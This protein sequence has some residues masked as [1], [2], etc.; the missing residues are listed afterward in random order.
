VYH[1]IWGVRFFFAG[2]G[3]MI[4]N[5]A[6]L[7]LSLIPI[8]VTGVL[9]VA[10]ALGITWFFGRLLAETFGDGIRS[11]LQVL[12][13]VA[14]L[15][16]SYFL[17][18][19]LG[20]ILLAPIA[21]ALSRKAHA[22]NTGANYSS[23]SNWWRAIREGIK[24]VML[25]SLI[26]IAAIAAGIVFPPIGVPLGIMVAVF[27]CGL[28]F[29]DIPLAARG[30]PLGNKLKVI[31][32]NKSLAMGFGCAAYLMLFVPGLNLLSL[33]VGVIGATLL[34]DALKVPSRA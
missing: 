33:P 24:M 34:T 30:L 22:I 2:L 27:L 19:P 6:L 4:R 28:E 16:V 7:G 3:M 12:V 15:V 29:F 5:P 23:E 1:L 18:L 9:L 31:F 14:V 20:R 11:I 13:F 21:E 25:H 8:V 10:I 32:G 17:Y 26:G